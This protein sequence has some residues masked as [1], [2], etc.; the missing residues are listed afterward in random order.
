MS[1][2]LQVSEYSTRKRFSDSDSIFYGYFFMTAFGVDYEVLAGLFPTKDYENV[3]ATILE[4][5]GG[6]F[7]RKS[8]DVDDF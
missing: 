7:I 2:N 3:I 5:S 1:L 4:N 6:G 8:V